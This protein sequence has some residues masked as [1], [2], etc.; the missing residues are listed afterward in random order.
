LVAEVTFRNRRVRRIES[1]AFHPSGIKLR[2]L[3]FVGT[4][5]TPLVARS[6]N[7]VLNDVEILRRWKLS[8]QPAA[9]A[10]ILVSITP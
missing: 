3:N 5:I 4:E 9:L 10:A 7:Q 6:H 8:T 1:T 2:V